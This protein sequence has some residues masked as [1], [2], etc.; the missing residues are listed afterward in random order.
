MNFN[1][2]KPPWGSKI[3]PP[4]EFSGTLSN[5]FLVT[6]TSHTIHAKSVRPSLSPSLRKV[7]LD[8]SERHLQVVVNEIHCH[9]PLGFENQEFVGGGKDCCVVGIHPDFELYQDNGKYL[10]RNSIGRSKFRIRNFFPFFTEQSECSM[11]I[12]QFSCLRLCRLS[13]QF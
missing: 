9:E 13:G 7:S 8:K 10:N 12:F 1:R 2:Y 11:E 3:P 6:Q 4:Q 5:E